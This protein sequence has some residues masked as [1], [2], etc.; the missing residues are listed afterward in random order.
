MDVYGVKIS[1]PDPSQID[2]YSKKYALNVHNEG[3]M[4]PAGFFRK[5]LHVYTYTCAF[6]VAQ[7]KQI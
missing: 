2:K 7:N 1:D 4:S 3:K 6:V 5:V